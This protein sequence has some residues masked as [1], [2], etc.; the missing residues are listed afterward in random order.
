MSNA[1]SE[2]LGRIFA[3]LNNKD[4][5]WEQALRISEQRLTVL[6]SNIANADTPNYKARDIDFRSALQQALA[7]SEATADATESGSM[8]PAK[9]EFVVPVVYRVPVQGAIDGNTVDMDVER[10]AFAE[11]ALKHE[12]FLQKAIDQYK[13]I[14]T[15]FKG[16]T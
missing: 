2:G 7:A 10:T 11:Q 15:L 5:F 14:A 13:E 1:K 16:M 8:L 12:F 9:S 4:E 3:P 6:A